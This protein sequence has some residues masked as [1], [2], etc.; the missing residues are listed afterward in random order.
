MSINSPLAIKLNPNT[1][2]AAPRPCLHRRAAASRPCSCWL[3]LCLAS[4]SPIHVFLFFIYWFS[5]AFFSSLTFSFSP[6]LYSIYCLYVPFFSFSF[7]LVSL[8]VSLLLFLSRSSYLLLSSSLFFLYLLFLSSFSK[9]S[10]LLQV[11]L[12]PS[13]A[14]LLSSFPLFSPSFPVSSIASVPSLSPSHTLLS[15]AVPSP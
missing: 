5:V 7:L 14:Y 8:L 11:F 9:H 3:S 2:L 4:Y 13:T 15:V 6:V 10:L 1:S 12:I